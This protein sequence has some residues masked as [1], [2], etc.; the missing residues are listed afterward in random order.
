MKI[1]T[2]EQGKLKKRFEVRF[3]ADQVGKICHLV[4]AESK[5][6]AK[7]LILAAYP[8][9]KINFVSIKNLG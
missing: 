5:A 7:G 4:K 2:K 3:I 6:K 8:K 1:R 9:R